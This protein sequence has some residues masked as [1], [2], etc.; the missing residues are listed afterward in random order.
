MSPDTRARLVAG[1]A[2]CLPLAMILG[3]LW[4][5]I[6]GTYGTGAE[7]AFDVS[8]PLFGDAHA[9]PPR[10]ID[11]GSPVSYD[12]PRD[13]RL[14]ERVRQ[15]HLDLWDPV[16]G[17]GAPLG[18]NPG[19]LFSP[20]RLILYGAPVAPYTAF[21]LF[22]V[23]RLLVA[24]LGAY[25]LARVHGLSRPA[26]VIV[27]A[28][29]GLSG[30]MLS[31]L[32]FASIQSVCWLPWVCWAQTRLAQQKALTAVVPVALTVAAM[33]T[34]GH[35]PIIA[36]MMMGALLHAAAI[37]SAQSGWRAKGRLAAQ[38]AAGYLLGA[39][40]A[41]P[42]LLSTAELLAN[43]HSYKAGDAG[44]TFREGAVRINRAVLFPSA[45]FPQSL[46]RLRDVLPSWA[47]PYSLA[48]AC[49]TLAY[50][51]AAAAVV[52][53]RWRREWTV[54]LL[55]GV[56][57]CFQPPGF[58]WMSTLPFLKD[59]LPRYTWPLFVLPIVVA[60]GAGADALFQR[61]RRTTTDPRVTSSAAPGSQSD[62][63]RR[64]GGLSAKALLATT[65]V[66]ALGAAA[67]AMLFWSDLP[68]VRTPVMAILRGPRWQPATTVVPLVVVLVAVLA[69]ARLSRRA[70]VSALWLL[71]LVSCGELA[72]I[73]NAHL[74]DTPSYRLRFPTSKKPRS[75]RKRSRTRTPGSVEFP[76]WSSDCRAGGKSDCWPLW[77]PSDTRISSRPPGA[78]RASRPST[79]RRIN[80]PLV[81][82][83]GSHTWSFPAARSRQTRRPRASPTSTA[84]RSIATWGRF[85]GRASSTGHSSWRPPTRPS[86]GSPASGRGSRTRRGHC[87]RRQRSS[88]PSRARRRR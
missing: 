80:R 65:G 88:N 66:F 85:P 23:A 3:L 8:D 35:Q 10:A 30:G 69:A 15:G 36:A 61:A 59:I 45:V 38:L 11:D 52:R 79:C 17:N 9:R 71:A 28:G 75:S 73:A 27:S 57:F 40:I 20:L 43:G 50:F 33:S 22:R 74:R 16:V 81:T 44:R 72:L 51:L 78:R 84:S 63:R 32:P 53:R 13:R 25:L 6:R 82:W 77:P 87:S 76:T 19:G 70:P 31:Q 48:F 14:I 86:A 56:V 39:L 60:A 47:Y 46:D 34:G 41:A 24:A 55:F 7:T 68:Q 54:M 1:A 26:C 5:N 83:R 42:A 49:G 2:V 29:F 58:V 62:A 18:A 12:W 37:A 21:V 67:M 64:R 4:P